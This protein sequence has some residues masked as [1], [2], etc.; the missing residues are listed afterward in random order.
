MT[1]EDFYRLK[2][3]ERRKDREAIKLFVHGAV[4]GDLNMFGD[5]ISLVEQS[6]LWARAFRAVA[7]CSAPRLLRNRF[8][9]SWKTSGDHIRCEVGND[10]V[11]IAGLRAFAPTV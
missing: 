4:T 2:A 7:G 9:E 3:E 8:V 6:C 5:G 10:L 11:L 1:R